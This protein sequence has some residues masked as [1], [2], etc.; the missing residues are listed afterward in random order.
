MP[1][2]FD[3][4]LK[5]KLGSYEAPYDPA[6]WTA[7]QSRLDA[8]GRRRRRALWI[9]LPLALSLG[10]GAIWW[11]FVSTQPDQKTTAGRNSAAEVIAG[12]DAAVSNKSIAGQSDNTGTEAAGFNVNGAP[13]NRLSG[14]PGVAGNAPEASTTTTVPTKQIVRKGLSSNPT[15]TDGQLM[16]TAGVQDQA[17]NVKPTMGRDPFAIAVAPANSVGRLFYPEPV[18]PVAL[19]SNWIGPVERNE[20]DPTLARDRRLVNWAI[21]GGAGLNA[22]YTAVG[23]GFRPGWDAGVGAEIWFKSGVFVSAGLRY[24]QYHFHQVDVGC[25]DP[26]AYGIQEPVHCPDA[27]LG[28]QGRWEVPL[29]AGYAWDLER[30]RGRFRISAGLTP[31]RVRKE[32]YRVEFHNPQPGV[33]LFYDPVTISVT[34]PSTDVLSFDANGLVESTSQFTVQPVGPQ[35][36]NISTKI[37]LAGEA[38]FGYEQF[39]APSISLG[40]EPRIGVPFNRMTLGEGRAYYGGVAARLRWYPGMFR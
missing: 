8:P 2:S 18:V 24:G 28:D 39:L 32:E 21:S 6:D 33:L 29:Q 37:H 4:Q 12:N 27:M 11:P 13:E 31:Q 20:Q 16:I 7:L 25:G 15:I 30:I 3:D 26:R 1:D 9:A 35:Q 22:E 34:S 36:S 10:A 17:V 38:G 23:D 5:D 14:N 40:I 19:A